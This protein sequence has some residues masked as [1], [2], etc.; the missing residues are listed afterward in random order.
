MYGPRFILFKMG[1]F[2]AWNAIIFLWSFLHTISLLFC[3]DVRKLERDFKEFPGQKVVENNCLDCGTFAN[4]RL[5]RSGRWSL[6]KLT[7]LVVLFSY[8]F[9]L[10]YRNLI[11][12]IRID[13]SLYIHIY[14]VEKENQQESWSA[15]EQVACAAPQWCPEDLRSH[16][17]LRTCNQSSRYNDKSIEINIEL[18][19]LTLSLRLSWMQN[20]ISVWYYI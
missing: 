16:G 4:H 14:L 7:V 18:K 11:S 13:R 12:K 5:M 9:V 19:K 1:H 8:Y 2:L 3:S 15:K 6:E 20:T 17:C 10:L